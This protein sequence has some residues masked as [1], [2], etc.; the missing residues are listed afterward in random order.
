MDG[1]IVHEECVVRQVPISASIFICAAVVGIAAYMV[2]LAIDAVKK[3]NSNYVGTIVLASI[4]LILCL[5]LLAGIIYKTNLFYRNLVVTISDD[6][7]FNEFTSRYEIISKE[8][9]LYTIREIQD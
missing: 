5:V 9:D 7:G 8:G 6:V 1:I 3:K 2:W 4:E